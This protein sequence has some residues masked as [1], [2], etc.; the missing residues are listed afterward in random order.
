MN[1][2]KLRYAILKEFDNGNRSF[3]YTDLGVEINV[4]EDQM[5]FLSREGYIQGVLYADDTVYS[6]NQVVLTEKGEKYLEENSKLSKLYRGLKEIKE[7]IM[8]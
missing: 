2:D 3:T 5:R 1:K 8:F 7:F 6:I 4:Y